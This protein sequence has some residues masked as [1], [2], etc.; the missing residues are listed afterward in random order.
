MEE[1]TN[2]RKI[3]NDP[4]YGFI[5]IP[6]ELVYDII[7]HPWFQRLR[8]IKQLG[9]THYVYP[10][11]Q[12]TRFQHAIGA[13]HLMIQAID[14]LRMKGHE[15]TKRE[16]EATVLAILLHD[17]GHGPF[18][19]T[20]ERTLVKGIHHEAISLLI[21]EQL[22]KEF[23]G[24]L[25]MAIRVFTDTYPKHFLHQ[26]VSSQLD[27]DRLDYLKRDSFFSGVQEG[28]INSDRIITMLNVEN[29]L[30]VVDAKGIYSIEKFIVARRLMYWQV[31]F[32][33]TVLA[34]E[35]MM[36]EILKRAKYLAG[37][38]IAVSAPDPLEVFLKHAFRDEHDPVFLNAFTR[39][40]DFDVF[41]AI[42][43]WANHPDRVLSLLCQNL[44]NRRLNQVVL[45]NNPAPAT[46]ISRIRSKGA[47]SLKI[48]N[49]EA[50]S[51]VY[52]GK[53][54]N[55]AYNPKK[56]RILIR[57]RDGHVED[58]A[59]S[60]DQLNVHVLSKTVSKYFLSFPKGIK[61]ETP[62]YR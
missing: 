15:I 8:R 59:E 27:M 33:K 48:S 18:S 23:K 47:R 25:K 36:V 30:L 44:V 7:E 32:H 46:L 12:H 31:Y 37:K 41:Y 11:A 51:F 1:I 61:V 13:M 29:D 40:D 60:S 20:L 28:V 5:S 45:L 4:I 16:R 55:D 56:D 39:L 42:K 14:I 22:N 6:D 19:H 58:I 53:I 9:L 50:A 35:Y 54:A 62:R 21:M 43:S 17:I 57:F 2:K 34:A 38:K 49:D 26:L 52:C 3:L 10:A 24:A